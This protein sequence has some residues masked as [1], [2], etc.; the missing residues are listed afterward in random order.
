MRPT[1][2][3]A[4]EGTVS[5]RSGDLAACHNAGATEGVPS[6]DRGTPGVVLLAAE[7][8]DHGL[9]RSP[10]AQADVLPASPARVNA[11]SMSLAMLIRRRNE[12]YDDGLVHNRR[13]ASTAV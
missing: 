8:D 13:W 1:L 11:G 7:R 5:G 6:I 10:W 3:F 4:P 2:L 9:V 12:R